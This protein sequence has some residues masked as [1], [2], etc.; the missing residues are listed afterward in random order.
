[1]CY[2]K[3]EFAKYREVGKFAKFA[4]FDAKMLKGFQLHGA[5]PPYPPTRVSAPGP[6]L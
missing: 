4:N 2:Y 1:M 5:K 6:P 3:H